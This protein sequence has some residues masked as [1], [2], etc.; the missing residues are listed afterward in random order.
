MARSQYLVAKI[1]LRT[2]LLLLSLAKE[3]CKLVYFEDNVKQN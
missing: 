2:I 1:N 3:I